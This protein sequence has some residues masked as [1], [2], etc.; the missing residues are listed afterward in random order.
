M[1]VLG[2]LFG[3]VLLVFWIFQSGFEVADA[4]RQAFAEGAEFGG[5]E[6]KQGDQDNDQPV[7]K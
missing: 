7:H 1:A 5:G 4:F 6:E 3:F 2:L